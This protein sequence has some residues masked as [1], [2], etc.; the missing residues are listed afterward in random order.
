MRGKPVIFS[1]NPSVITARRSGPDADVVVG[2][3]VVVVTAMAS[4][5]ELVVPVSALTGNFLL[6]SS[7]GIVIQPWDDPITPDNVQHFLSVVNGRREFV[8]A[9][10]DGFNIIF[11]SQVPGS[12]GAL[13]LTN[14]DIP[15]RA[16]FER[17][18]ARDAQLTVNG[19]AV[20]TTGNDAEVSGVTVTARQVGSANLTLADS[21]APKWVF[22]LTM[23]YL[24]AIPV[25]GVLRHSEPGHVLRFVPATII[26]VPTSVFLFGALG[27]VLISLQGIF[28]HNRS[29]LPSY[30]YWHIARPFVAAALAFVAVL[31]FVALINAAQASS[32]TTPSPTTTS[33]TTTSLPTTTTTSP[34]STTTSLPTTTTTTTTTSLTTTTT[35]SSTTT[36]T[37]PTTTTTSPT[38]T[39][40][41]SAGT[42]TTSVS[43]TTS[44]AS[45]TT[46]TLSKANSAPGS[47]N[48]SG[49]SSVIVYN[50]IGFIVGYREETF[51]ALLTK[52]T[53]V[54]L[55]PGG[56][57][58]QSPSSP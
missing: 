17:T 41:T 33:P 30:E 44:G 38:T 28:K 15:I 23:V 36:T 47:A 2:V 10:F 46:T 53:D 57:N 3:Y 19:A 6:S 29:W 49:L 20:T 31:I 35:T 54:L 18:Q 45:T 42:S 13:S 43:P 11:T 52:I 16:A 48:S 32:S 34:P 55:G 9:E 56:A 39:S 12:G 14:K 40:T 50:I 27:G 4:A 51:R 25:I 58:A 8:H 26:G 21:R 7:Q 24:A 37:S 22:P 1:S 5:Q